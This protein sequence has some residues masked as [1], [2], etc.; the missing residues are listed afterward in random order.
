MLNGQVNFSLKAMKSKGFT[1]RVLAFLLTLAVG[2]PAPVFALRGQQQ[3][4]PSQ[5]AGLEEVLKD[6]EK[7]LRQLTQLV[8]TPA[9]PATPLTTA[10]TPAASR[11]GLEESWIPSRVLQISA[12][13]L[14]VPNPDDFAARAVEARKAGAERIHF[15]V[16]Q[17]GDEKTSLV[18]RI[19]GAKDTTDIFTPDRL[20]QIKQAGRQAGLDIPV[21][22]H[23]VM[24][25]PS[26][27]KIR[28][29]LQAG[30]DSIGLHWEAYPDDGRRLSERLQLI[31]GFSGKAVLV[32]SPDAD[33]D[34]VGTFLSKAGEIVDMVSLLAVPLGVGGATFQ[35]RALGH[36]RRLRERYGYA[37]PIQIDGG[38]EPDFSSPMARRAGAD[39]LVA[40]SAF[41]GRAGDRDLKALRQAYEALRGPEAVP[42][43]EM[44]QRCLR[45]GTQYDAF[46][47]LPACPACNG[48]LEF[49][50]SDFVDLLK[51]VTPA[52]PG[53]WRYGPLLPVRPK[54]VVTSGEG[55]TPIVKLE[56]LSQKLGIQL[57]AK[58]ESENPTGTFKDREASFVVSRARAA[59][60]DNLVLQSTGNTALAVSYYAGVA[61][62]RSYAFVPAR[63]AYKLIGPHLARGNKVILVEGD[64]IDVKNYATQFAKAHGFPK[65]SPFHERSEANATQA[66]EVVEAILRGELPNLDFYVQTIAAG[67]GPIGFYL[68]LERARRWTHGRIALPRVIGVQISEFAPVHRAWEGDLD[69]VGPEGQTPTYGVE[70]P[71]EP[72]L[73]TTNAPA[74]YSHIRTALKQSRGNLAVVDPQ[75]ARGGEKEFRDSLAQHGYQLTNTENSSFIGYAGLVKQVA[76]GMIPKGSTVLLMV[77]GKGAKPQFE[78]IEPDAVVLPQYDPRRLRQQLEAGETVRAGK[79]ARAYQVAK[80]IAE[81]EGWA[82][83]KVME[84]IY[85]G[86]MNKA[87]TERRWTSE[88]ENRVQGTRRFLISGTMGVTGR[89]A[90]IMRQA[91]ERYLKQ[92]YP[93]VDFR[94]LPVPD[95]S[96]VASAEGAS[97]FIPT[98][99]I[100]QAIHRLSQEPHAGTTR[101]GLL[102]ADVG[103]TKTAILTLGIDAEGRLSQPGQ[104]LLSREIPT[105]KWQDRNHLFEEVSHALKRVADEAAG[106]GI[107]VLPTIG[108]AFASAFVNPRGGITYDGTD[109][110]IAVGS[111]FDLAPNMPGAF[112]SK[113]LAGRLPG[114]DVFVVNDG[115]AQF[116]Y[117]VD[118]ALRMS[119][120]RKALLGEQ[121]V[122]V[123]P[124]TGLGA[125]FGR[126]EQDGNVIFFPVTHISDLV[127]T[128]FQTGLQVTVEVDGKRFEVQVPT[129]GPH[130]WAKDF[131]SGRAVETIATA[132]DRKLS[133]AGH[134]PALL[135]RVENYPQMTKDE[136]AAAL[137]P[138]NR[139]TPLTAKLIN[140]ILSQSPAAG[141]SAKLTTGLEER[142]PAWLQPALGADW[143]EVVYGVHEATKVTD[144]VAVLLQPEL[145]GVAG[146]DS[147]TQVALMSME[148]NLHGA[149]GWP[150]ETSLRLGLLT[151]QSVKAFEGE[152]YRVI[153]VVRHPESEERPLPWEA[154]P[155]VVAEALAGGQPTFWVN[156]TPYL[157]LKGI[158]LPE[159]L[160]TLTDLF[161]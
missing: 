73:H 83:G 9:P 106:Q 52:W 110:P 63:S 122:L 64:P 67:M 40:G 127:V 129:P 137:D 30:A 155:V 44:A 48:D 158:T 118:A 143:M 14:A 59:G 43:I 47:E 18:R 157:N 31:H 114:Y 139:R 50:V 105:P 159:I 100:Q 119:E 151:P 152:G 26:E 28:E 149:L 61:G 116:R 126:V 93:G 115:V 20:R 124:G 84:T 37:G 96:G 32:V 75:E 135:P 142:V 160:S 94:L 39:I 21:D 36:L 70:Q 121:V 150:D 99:K 136:I 144:K 11:A 72:T 69:E 82:M 91:A 7:A 19:P 58:I 123:A 138:N 45:C 53:M 56:D 132:I 134:P 112:P 107:T 68:G 156:V 87:L 24:R 4:D 161:A 34:A 10:G 81:Y 103:G 88:D 13:L 140:E 51:S 55:N 148:G 74:Y 3:E 89:L 54:D 27:E 111:G 12:S 35:P 57:Y 17:V 16:I 76:E 85:L 78:Q 62:L 97:Y 71:F 90:E 131:L 23:L 153:R 8:T 79:D 109:N 98:E 15:D 145:L 60:Q 42:Q 29:F 2:L 133:E 130:R 125:G 120:M 101:F 113:E 22:V 92:R 104:P 66:Y 5:L 102:V 141:G 38:M 65:L 6:P 117:V 154:V 108:V 147:E 95:L 128:D 41:F 33:I 25:N 46:L 49:V 86:R 77:T 80:A 1:P 146:D